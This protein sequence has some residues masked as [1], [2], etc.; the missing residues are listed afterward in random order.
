MNRIARWLLLIAV[1]IV[2]GLWP[3]LAVVPITH[4]ADGAA[5]IFAAIPAPVLLA[6]GYIA[7][8]RHKPAA[9]LDTAA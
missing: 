6:A 3:P 7:W 2:V 8:L 4:A 9:R 1:L 5:A